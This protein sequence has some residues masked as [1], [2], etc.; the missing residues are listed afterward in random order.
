VSS[1]QGTQADTTCLKLYFTCVGWGI[2]GNDSGAVILSS[3]LVGSGI[4]GK[5]SGAANVSAG[6]A[7]VDIDRSSGISNR[8]GSSANF[9]IV[10]GCQ[11]LTNNAS[12][13]RETRPPATSTS[14]GP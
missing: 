3:G 8:P 11:T 14:Q 4:G 5:D 6:C 9:Q 7:G 2:G 10:R 12:A 1:T 13:T